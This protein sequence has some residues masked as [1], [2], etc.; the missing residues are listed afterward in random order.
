MNND[1]ERFANCATT[2]PELFVLNKGESTQ[3]AKKICAACTVRLKCLE[4]ALTNDEKYGVWGGL[5]RRERKA[6]LRERR[7]A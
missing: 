5:S 3:E 7:V 4:T 6:L 1:W 2:D